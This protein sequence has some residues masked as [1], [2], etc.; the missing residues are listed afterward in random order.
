MNKISRNELRNVLLNQASATPVTVTAM[1]DARAKKT[2]N[3]FGRIFKMSRVNGFTGFS[4]ENSVNRQ[5]EREGKD[6]NFE[7]QNRSWGEKV[8]NCLVEKDGEWYISLKVEK[9]LDKPK[10][11]YYDNQKGLTFLSKDKIENLLPK[12]HGAEKQGLDKEVI[13]RNYKLESIVSIAINGQLYKV[14]R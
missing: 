13:Y 11:L 5:R 8:N 9:V 4:Y 3:P 12:S 14:R 6:K 2:N 10:Y 1:T 7:A